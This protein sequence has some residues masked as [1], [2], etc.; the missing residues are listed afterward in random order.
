MKKCVFAISSPSGSIVCKETS[1]VRVGSSNFTPYI[2][3]HYHPHNYCSLEIL[4][5]CNAFSFFS[6]WNH[7][8]KIWEFLFYFLGLL[9]LLLSTYPSSLL[10]LYTIRQFGT[11]TRLAY[12]VNK[13]KKQPGCF[14]HWKTFLQLRSI[15]GHNCSNLEVSTL[16]FRNTGWTLSENHIFMHN[17]HKTGVILIFIEVCINQIEITLSM[18]LQELGRDWTCTHTHN[19]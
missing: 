10:L 14:L 3:S 19:A 4:P 2:L 12:L 15:S 9:S 16:S 18:G 11:G 5:A 17:Q 13:I 6:V 7:F 1:R 8:F